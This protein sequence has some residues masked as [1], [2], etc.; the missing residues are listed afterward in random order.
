MSFANINDPAAVSALLDQLRASQAWRDAVAAHPQ[1]RSQ[2]QSQSQSSSSVA[3]LLSQLQPSAPS[4]SGSDLD[5][6]GTPTPATPALDTDPNPDRTA[7]AQD[8][9]LHL[10][11]YSF[12]QALPIIVKLSNDPAFITEIQKLKQAQDELERHLWE[13]RRA[14]QGKHEEKVKVSKTKATMIGVGLSKHEADMLNDA[15]KKELVKF[16]TERV[17]PAFDGL[18]A[19]Q[20]TALARLNV[21]TMSAGDDKLLQEQQQRIMQVLTGLV[22]THDSKT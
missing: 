10:K 14:I 9:H 21:P 22:D 8:D 5:I 19:K 16:D 15:Y 17:L 3:V 11:T 12:Q 2:S 6:P 1:P 18:V 7:P 13:E 20:Q 4:S